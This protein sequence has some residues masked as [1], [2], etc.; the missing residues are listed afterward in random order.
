MEK[1]TESLLSSERSLEHVLLPSIDYALPT[2]GQSTRN[3][4]GH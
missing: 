2:R 4:F 1:I 3:G